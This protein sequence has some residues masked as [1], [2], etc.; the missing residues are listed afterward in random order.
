MRKLENLRMID[1]LCQDWV[2]KK[3]IWNN[4]E[5]AIRFETLPQS[6]FPDVMLQL[7]VEPRSKIPFWTRVNGIRGCQMFAKNGGKSGKSEF[8]DGGSVR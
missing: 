7:L 5:G 1:V 3:K 6:S 2:T 4:S 8:A